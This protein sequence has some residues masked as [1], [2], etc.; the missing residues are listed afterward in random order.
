MKEIKVGK[1]CLWKDPACYDYEGQMCE[2][3][4]REFT[5]VS[6]GE[7]DIFENDDD[8]ILLSDGITEVQTFANE[9]VILD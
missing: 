8:I 4:K 7:H 9:I 2:A 5:I 3:L 1:T 6:I